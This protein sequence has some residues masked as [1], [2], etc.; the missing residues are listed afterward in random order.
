MPENVFLTSG[1]LG[2][3]IDLAF[4]QN[5][6]QENFVLYALLCDTLTSLIKAEAEC[7]DPTKLLG[8]KT[9]PKGMHFHPVV[10]K[11]CAELAR[12]CGQGG[13]NLVREILP[14]PSLI[15]VNSYRQ[16]QKSYRVVSPDNL[17]LFSQELTRPVASF[18]VNK[19][20]AKTLGNCG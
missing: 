14:I 10:L 12:K 11:R 16:S 5:L 3:L 19:L 18:P 2:L 15:T 13:Y 4:S 8:K 7:K 9:Q 6:L 17:K 1:K 20:N